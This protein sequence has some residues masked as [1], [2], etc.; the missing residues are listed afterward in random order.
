M[1]GRVLRVALAGNPNV[2]KTSLFNVLTGSRHQVGNYSG[3]TVERREGDLARRFEAAGKDSGAAMRLWDLPGI[4]SLSPIS[5]DEAVALEALVGSSAGARPDVVLLV[6]DAS[7]LARNL[8]L[9]LQVL[10]LGIPLVIALN[11]VDVA[12][13]AGLPVHPETLRAQLGVPVVSTVART[14]EG[15]AEVIAAVR[16]VAARS[17]PVEPVLVEPRAEDDALR[18]ALS[19]AELEVR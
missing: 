17:E 16:E 1:T 11:M 6:I 12:R 18:D 7:N 15:A 14:G 4:Y 5:E 2:G 9:A 10:E 13:R 3:V 8:Y 19:V